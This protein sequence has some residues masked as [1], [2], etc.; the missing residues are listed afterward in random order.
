MLIHLL[1]MGGGG[2]SF[3]YYYNR[4]LKDPWSKVIEFF[5]LKWSIIFC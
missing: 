5:P 3:P 4:V 1:V 2:Y